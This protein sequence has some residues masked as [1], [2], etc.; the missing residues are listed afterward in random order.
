MT[1]DEAK[2]KWCPFARM[3]SHIYSQDG[4]GRTFEGGYSY[5]R[6]PDHGEGYLPTGAKCIG[7]ACMAW[8][9]NDMT[10]D[11][12]LELWSK[13]KGQRVNSAYSDDADWRPVGG[14]SEPP[15]PQ[16]YCGLAG[17]P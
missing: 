4:A 3:L 9:W 7:S 6:S 13:S 14:D 12:P 15:T 2:T 11:R 10:Y 5:N 1:E 16:G 8:R 17:K